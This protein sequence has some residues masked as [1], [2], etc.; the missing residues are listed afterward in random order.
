MGL[1]NRM[2]EYDKPGRRDFALMAVYGLGALTAMALAVPAAVYLL[3]PPRPRKQ[4]RWTDAGDISG[5]AADQPA[6]IF[7]RRKRVDGWKITA[8]R[9]SAWVSRT[10]DGNLRAFSPSCTHLGCAYH[11]DAQ[12]REFLCPCHGSVFA[13]DG[14]VKAGPASRPLDRYETALKAGHLWLGELIQPRG[15]H[16]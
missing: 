15:T 5:V 13:M 4:P 9:D 3:Y 7:F 2:P 1:G 11:W 10:P 6:Q 14:S 8:E 12:S 16:S